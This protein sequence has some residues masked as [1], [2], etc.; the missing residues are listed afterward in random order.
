MD[1]KGDEAAAKSVNGSKLRPIFLMAVDEASQ[2][3]SNM[4]IHNLSPFIRLSMVYCGELQL[5][6]EN[7]AG[8]VPQ[9][10]YKLAPTV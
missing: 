8:L 1:S 10:W 3:V 5:H 9:C 7:L 4:L 2:S 6:S